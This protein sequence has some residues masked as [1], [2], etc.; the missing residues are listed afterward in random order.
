MRTKNQRTFLCS[1]QLLNPS[2]LPNPSISTLPTQATTAKV[3]A[4]NQPISHRYSLF[5][6]TQQIYAV[7]MCVFNNKTFNRPSVTGQKFFYGHFAMVIE[8]LFFTFKS[9]LL[10]FTK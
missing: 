6:I 3:L 7:P 4:M 8:I 1:G 5:S 10:T 9:C 2:P